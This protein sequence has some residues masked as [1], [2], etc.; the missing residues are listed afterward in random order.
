[1]L[2]ALLFPLASALAPTPTPP[3][4]SGANETVS[5]ANEAVEL[6]REGVDYASI[7][8]S[9]KARLIAGRGG[10]KQ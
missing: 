4:V 5:G 8:Q 2:N 6:L 7:I 1:M 10:G 3:T 9:L